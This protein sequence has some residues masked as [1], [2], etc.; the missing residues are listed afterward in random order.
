MPRGRRLEQAGGMHHVTARTPKGLLLFKVPADRLLYL[1]LLADVAVELD[2]SIR[3][4]CLMG[5]HIHL[6]VVTPSTDLGAGIKVIHETFVRM[7]HDRHGTYGPLLQNYK[8]KLVTT[9]DHELACLRYVARNPVKDGF[10]ASPADWEWSAHRALAGLS[11][12]PDFLDVAA[13][14]RTIDPASYV[15]VA[16]TSDL[17]LLD[18]LA[19]A[20]PDTWLAAAADD[21]LIRVPTIA[22]HLGVSLATTYRRLGEAREKKGNLP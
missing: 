19:A 14:R 21:H 16:E 11:A 13:V 3:T 22:A 17:R 2:W 9:I 15:R 6:V 18:Q 12:P 20:K 1:T 8:N 10:C 7:M 5:T 4:Y